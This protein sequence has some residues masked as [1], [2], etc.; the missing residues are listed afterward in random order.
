MLEKDNRLYVETLDRC[1][2]IRTLR[3]EEFGNPKRKS[4]V[5]G[6]NIR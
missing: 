2:H 3:R 5:E 4:R 6:R 1:I